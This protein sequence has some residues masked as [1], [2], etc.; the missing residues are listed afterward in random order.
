M[1]EYGTYADVAELKSR[2]DMD[3]A[4]TDHDARLLEALEDASRQVDAYCRRHFYVVSATRFYSPTKGREFLFPDDVLQITALYGDRDNKRTWLD[5]WTADDYELYPYNRFPK[6]AIR[7]RPGGSY[8]FPIGESRLKVVGLFG[9]GDGESATPY[10]AAGSTV[11]VA[12][13]DGTA[14][15]ASSGAAFKVGNTVLAGSEQM[16]VTGISGNTL[17]VVRGVNGTTTA[18]HAAATAYIYRYP[19]EV[20][21][22]TLLRAQKSYRR[23]DAPGGTA[24]SGEFATKIYADLDRDEQR[25]LHHLRR[26][27][28][29]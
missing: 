2:L 28:V 27:R 19:L 7:R 14:V 20:R 12:T 4:D 13:T 10:R 21:T 5:V 22:V 24:N 18:V 16:Y 23:D 1:G 3:A 25:R 15:T 17:T 26:Q 29:A 9:F 8:S 11:T 6:W